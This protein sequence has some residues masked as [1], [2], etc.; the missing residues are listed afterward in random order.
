MGLG[1][2]RYASM[3]VYIYMYMYIYIYTCVCVCLCVRVCAR[4]CV[5]VPGDGPCEI[6]NVDSQMSKVMSKRN[7]L[8]A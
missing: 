2:Q 3:Y 5:W 1:S 8:K 6:R 4:A 7:V